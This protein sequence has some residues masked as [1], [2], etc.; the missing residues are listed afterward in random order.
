MK[1]PVAHR[2]DGTMIASESKS[3][4]RSAL[5]KTT[6]YEDLNQKIVKPDRKIDL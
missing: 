1:F 4:K 2:S 3:G 5:F 6:V